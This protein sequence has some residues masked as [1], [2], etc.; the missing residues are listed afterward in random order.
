MTEKLPAVERIHIL[1]NRI[2]AIHGGAG[3]HPTPIHRQQAIDA[4]QSALNE[5]RKDLCRELQPHPR[6]VP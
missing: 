4:A 3:N 6:P 1:T 2:K 5:A